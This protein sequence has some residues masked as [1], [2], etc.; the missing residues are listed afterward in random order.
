[1]PAAA[2]GGKAQIMDHMAPDGDVY[3]A[4]TLSGNPL[5]MAAGIAT[6][7]QLADEEVYSGLEQSTS[8]LAEGLA[9]A[10]ARAGVPVQCPHVG[11]MLCCFFRGEPVTN[12]EQ[13]LACDT[14]AFSRFFGA[15]LERGVVL[16]PSQFETWFV[17][18]AHDAAA[19]KHTVAAAA[20][21]FGVVAAS[22]P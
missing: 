3:Q 12:Y 9:G 15:M 7:E 21:A 8:T 20:E 10:A 4:G 16:P 19:I 6:L 22:R 13:A 11:S 17:S 14:E 1:M 18:T 2:F 5:V